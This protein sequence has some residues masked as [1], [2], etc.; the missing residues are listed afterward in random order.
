MASKTPAEVCWIFS[1]EDEAIARELLDLAAVLEGQGLVRNWAP[2]A[3]PG[4]MSPG[5]SNPHR[6]LNLERLDAAARSDVVMVLAGPV[7]LSYFNPADIERLAQRTRLVLVLVRPVSLSGWGA[8]QVQLPR[9]GEPLLAR[10]NRRDGLLDVIRGLQ[11][12]VEFRPT[13]EPVAVSRG[14]PSEDTRGLSIN[15]IFRLDGPPS[16]TFVEPPLFSEL[17]LALRTMGTGLVVEGPSKV[18][19]TTA[20][21]KVM[22]SLRVPEADQIWWDGREPPPLDH[23]RQTLRELRDGDHNRW[24]FIDDFH[25]VEDEPYRRQLAFGMK[26]LADQAQPH[27]KVTLIGINP[28]GSSLVDVMPDLSGRFRIYRLD[29]EKDWKGSTKIA[30]VIFRGERAAN[31]R[32][33]RRDEFVVAA[34][35]SFFLA[36]YL[37][38]VAAVKSG[39]QAVQP[40]KVEIDLGPADAVAAIQGELAA[41]FRAPMLE[42]AAFDAMPPPRGAGVSLLWLLARSPDGF[43]PLKEARLRFPMLGAAFEWFLE[44]NLTRCFHEHPALRSLLY[45]NRATTTLTMEDPQLKFYLRE[46]DWEKFAEASGHGRVSF[47]P[48]D[49]PVWS[50]AIDGTGHVSSRA[51][52][53]AVAVAEGSSTRRVL[54]LSDLHFATKDQ[55]TISY[56]QLAADLRQQGVPDRLDALIVS[57]DLVNRADPAEYDAARLFLEHLMAGFALSGRQVTL[58]PGNHDVS[59]PLAESAY[60]LR[61]RSQQRGALSPGTY[62]EHGDEVIEVRDEEAYRKRFQ[63]FSDL[64]RLIKG[65]EYPLDYVDQGTFDDPPNSGLLILGLNSAWEIDHHFRDRASI[66]SEALAR[67]L[68]KLGPPSADQLRIAVFHHPIH[69]GEDSRI[70]DLGFLQQL[71]VAGFRVVLHG[72]V[73]KADAELYRYDRVA[74]GRQIEIVA[75]GTFGAPTHEWVPGYPL[76]YNLLLVAPDKITVETRCRRE[77]NGAWEADARWRQG[78][79]PGQDPLPRYI[80]E[81]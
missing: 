6:V 47:H 81:R 64:Y 38:N 74:G 43:V 70:R 55:A 13:E 36:Q 78:P 26:G 71:A 8:V 30:E 73:H 51:M 35:G 58:V 17:K 4:P 44:S 10:R 56:A 48:E 1:D 54:H 40:D 16:V 11:E 50:V 42:F 41:R 60:S 46:L 62:K 72:H 15:E 59:W 31:I 19:K 39:I 49:G 34:G 2:L 22:E 52:T 66:H 27:G 18:G 20:I 75:A 67:A 24:L 3:L 61:K 63:P 25:Y 23:M 5:L 69:S 45:Y 12:I 65:V 28:L 76:E 68:L 21:R 53:M 57:G 32:F 29:V 37:C 80:I 33:K 9:D 14:G 79:G 77:V 7:S